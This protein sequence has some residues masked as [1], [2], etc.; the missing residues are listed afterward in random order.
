MPMILSLVMSKVGRWVIVGLSIFLAVFG[1]Y[2]MAQRSGRMAERQKQREQSYVVSKKQ[3]VI[4]SKSRDPADV[5]DSL[6]KHQF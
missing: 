5:A 4:A 1:A 3:A 6:R 2:K